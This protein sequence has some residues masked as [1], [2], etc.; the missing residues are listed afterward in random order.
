MP[1]KAY[2]IH[3]NGGRPFRVVIKGSSVEVYKKDK[4]DEEDDAYSK[5]IDTFPAKKVFVGKSSGKSKSCDHTAKQ[6]KQFDGNSILVQTGADK[7]VYIGHEVFSF[8]LKDDVDAYYSPVGNN[9]VP[10]P[11]IL[12]K[13][14]VYFMLDKKYVPRDM[15]PKDQNW[16]DAY[17]PYYGTFTPEKGW[18]SEYAPAAK[19]LKTKLIHKRVW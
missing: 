19:K 13:E 18:V 10:Y 3:D 4:G 9:D 12:G 16:E 6:A 14:F 17:G 11:L 15:F 2:L 7:Y 8:E 5:M 1:T